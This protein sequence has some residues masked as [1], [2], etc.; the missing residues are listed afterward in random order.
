[1]DGYAP[2]ELVQKNDTC[3]LGTVLEPNCLHNGY[4]AFPAECCIPART[5][6]MIA[7]RR[8]DDNSVDAV[9]PVS[10]A[11]PA[12]TLESEAAALRADNARLREQL[13]LRNHALD[14]TTTFFV[15]TQFRAPEAVIVYCN[16]AVADQHGFT[17]EELIG[18]PVR[19]LTQWVA[20]NS[21]YASDVATAMRAG[22]TF[23]YEDEVARRDGSTFWL[24]IAIRPIFDDTGRLT[25][26]VAVGADITA[27][28]IEIHKKQELQ[29]KLL[30]EMKERER[31]VIE[32]QL[33]QKLESVGRLAAG[34]A[35]EINTPIQY[36]GDSVHFLRSACD[37]FNHLLDSWREAIDSLPDTPVRDALRLEIAESMKRCDMDFLSTQMPKAFERIFDGV[38]RVTNIVKAMKE[39]AHPDAKEQSPSDLNRALQTTLLV[40]S[41]EYKYLATVHTDLADL[42]LIVCNIGELNQVFLNLIVNAAH[43]IHD[44][45]KDL[46]SGEIRISTA[47]AGDVAVVRISDNGCGVPAENLSKLFDP[48]FTTKEVG[49]GTGQGL[50]ISHSI[51]VD[52]HGGDISVQSSVGVGTEFTLRL[53]VDGRGARTGT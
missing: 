38:E 29:D 35:H 47:L 31:M 51:L 12:L 11:H 25:H 19:I 18:Q 22:Q 9:E 53:P 17:R 48:F 52:K 39:F 15:I 4:A 7:G 1:M 21:N 41:N 40:A 44:A 3:Q 28:R 45:G 46:N 14:A 50:A 33:A 10:P 42:P 13:A 30:E 20:S 24:G 36:V 2:K 23:H 32:L 27:K 16:R 49:R 5:P 37:D 26:S 34:I 8:P 6:T 43:A